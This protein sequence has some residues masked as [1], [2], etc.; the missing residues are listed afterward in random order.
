VLVA[1]GQ[2]P[3]LGY[4]DRSTFDTRHGLPV[5]DRL[6][7][8]VP[9]V[10]AAGDI[11]S[12]IDPFIGGRTRHGTWLNAQN[13][14]RAAARAM[15]GAPEPYR[16]VPWFWSDHFGINVQV[17]GRVDETADIVERRLPSG[18]VSYFYLDGRQVVGAVGIDARRDV[19]AAMLLM[20]A[21]T[22]VDPEAVRDARTDLRTAARAAELTRQDVTP[23]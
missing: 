7:S 14:G 20:E 6:E 1:I 12:F 10:F 23:A 2:H 15:L 8:A 9:G 19:R 21:G 3:A 17:A 22:P 16:S 18:G 5:D 4:L 11:A 13:Q